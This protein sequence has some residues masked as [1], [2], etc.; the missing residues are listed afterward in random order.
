MFD[1]RISL[2]YEK[3]LNDEVELHFI[4]DGQVINSKISAVVSALQNIIP[5]PL[6]ITLSAR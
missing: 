6:A 4:S 2:L 1:K 3:A 5:M